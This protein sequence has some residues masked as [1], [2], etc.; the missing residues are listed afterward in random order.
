MIVA[1]VIVAFYLLLA[2]GSLGGLVHSIVLQAT[3]GNGEA[4]HVYG[5]SSDIFSY[6]R[7]DSV[8]VV[9]DRGLRVAVFGADVKGSAFD[10]LVRSD[11]ECVFVDSLVI[12]TPRSSDGPPD[13]SLA[14]IFLGT[15][16]GMVTRTDTIK[17]SYGRVVNDDGLLLVDSMKFNARIA[18]IENV[19]LDVRRASAFI[20][21]FGTVQ[22]S[23]F[24]FIDSTRTTL[25]GF[26]IDCPPGSLQLTGYLNADSTFAVIF[27]GSVSTGFI[28]GVPSA[29]GMITGHGAGS[30]MDPLAS[31]S[32]SQGSM[33]YRGL[34]IGLAADSIV[35]SRE[36]CTLHGLSISTDGV[37]INASGGFEFSDLAWQGSAIGSLHGADVSTFF[38]ESP[39]TDITGGITASGSGTGSYFNNGRVGCEFDRSRVSDYL[40]SSLIL[41][42]AVDQRELS[43]TMQAVF[44]GGSVSSEFSTSLGLDFMPVAWNADLDA[45]IADCGIFAA[46]T[47]P[48]VAGAGGLTVKAS[49]EGSMSAFTLN[50][51]IGLGTF[52]GGGI[53]VKNAAFSGT[54]SSGSSGMLINGE[55]TVDSAAVSDSIQLSATELYADV[56][57]SGEPSDFEASGTVGFSSI[58]YNDLGAGDMTFL[59][60]VSMGSSGIEGTGRLSV[61]SIL[62]AGAPYSLSA[63]FTAEPGSVHLDSLSLGAPG[64]LSLDLSGHFRYGTDSLA[65]SM[66]G[67]ALTRAGKLRLISQGDLEFVTDSSGM[68]LDTLWLDLPSGELQLTAGCAEILSARRQSWL[69]LILPLSPQCSGS[70][71]PSREFLRLIFHPTAGWVIFKRCCQRIFSTLPMTSGISQTVLLS[72]CILWRI[73]LL[74]MVSGPGQVA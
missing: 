67:I 69:M 40:L 68:T 41:D 55:F 60:D 14:P 31:I 45:S 19:E 21:Q 59:G 1:L 22:A 33:N 27:S 64:D 42:C 47:Y 54:V 38:P 49:G 28:P 53:G 32:L 20:P 43:G 29:S 46:F 7:A 15:L 25:E 2:S 65:F 39:S 48:V 44:D 9:N 71:F 16:S 37:S 10:Y 52:S 24:L 35:S 72:T 63:V 57:V 11:V 66:D 8:V 62:M 4:V 56:D 30:I 26:D 74:W 58:Q 61:D 6:V 23:G 70:V 17:V 18:D 5:G 73:P 3:S 12:R 34:L 50:G 13:S 36:Q 51:D